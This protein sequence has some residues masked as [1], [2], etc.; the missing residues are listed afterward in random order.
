[1]KKEEKTLHDHLR[2][3]ENLFFIGFIVMMSAIFFQSTAMLIPYILGALIMLAA[4][5]YTNKHF[6]CPH[7]DGKLNLRMKV[8]NFC[9][10]CGKK[11]T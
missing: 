3:I 10:H 11:L 8:P 4:A 5:W 2:I 7:C 9:P 1:M 6:K